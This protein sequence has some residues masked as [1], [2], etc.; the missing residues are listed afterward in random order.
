MIQEYLFRSSEHKEELQNFAFGRIK[1]EIDQIDNSECWTLRLSVPGN[2]ENDAKLL[3]DA[4]DIIMG[5]CHP[6]VLE[7]GCSAYY[8]KKL[9]PLMNEF[10]RDLRKL[11]YLHSALSKEQT[12]TNVTKNLEEKN[13]DEIFN[14]WFFDGA[15]LPK[16]CQF[17][18][19]RNLHITKEQL[20]FQIQEVPETILWDLLIGKGA[21][22]SLR[23]NF[24][25]VK[26][27]RND[28]MHAHNISHERYSSAKK[29]IEKVNKEIKEEIG[30]TIQR[31]EENRQTEA[32]ENFNRELS[33]SELTSR[34]LFDYFASEEYKKL[35]ALSLSQYSPQQTP[36]I[37]A[38]LEEWKR[39]HDE[40]E[41][42]K[43]DL[44]ASGL[45]LADLQELAGMQAGLQK[46]SD[47]LAA[48][49]S[50]DASMDEEKEENEENANGQDEN[51]NS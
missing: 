11:L 17:V 19:N 3:S 30:K 47:W 50:Y 20:I 38:F 49:A 44:L 33:V 39:Q 2:G 7:N 15:F 26:A 4:H 14:Q 34:A 32:D 51:G 10:E 9:F 45:S 6:T 48:Q 46:L 23:E 24:K 42:A 27:Y 13:L 16:I 28:V 31:K 18:N 37:T 8:N 5:K 25:Q 29:L 21:V 12:D 40:V 43:K 1:V 36:G 41:Q 35:V 22:P